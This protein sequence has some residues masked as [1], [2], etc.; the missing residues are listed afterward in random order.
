MKSQQMSSQMGSTNKE[1]HQIHRGDI[2]AH[3]IMD[4]HPPLSPKSRG[5]S[6]QEKNSYFIISLHLI[7]FHPCWSSVCIN[8][9]DSIWNLRCDL[10]KCYV[11]LP[12]AVSHTYIILQFRA[13]KSKTQ[14]L[15]GD[16]TDS[17]QGFIHEVCM[18]VLAL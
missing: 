18:H 8:V 15:S 4:Y 2:L 11:L 6:L 14:H 5:D 17:G 13:N 7:P 12:Y 16:I 10:L 9:W 3:L 1:M